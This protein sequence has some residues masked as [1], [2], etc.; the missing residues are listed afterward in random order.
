MEIEPKSESSKMIHL[1]STFQLE[2]LTFF[3]GLCSR[4]WSQ[5]VLAI[6]FKCL[7]SSILIFGKLAPKFVGLI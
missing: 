4:P 5:S 3:F 2:N 7:S 1:G 6:G